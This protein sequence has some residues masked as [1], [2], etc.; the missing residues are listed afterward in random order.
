MARD[1]P[2][3]K[4]DRTIRNIVMAAIG[5][6]VFVAG[7]LIWQAYEYIGVFR[8]LAEWQFATFDRMYPLV[9]IAAIVLILSIPFLIA[10]AVLQMRRRKVHGRF[11][12]GELLVRERVGSRIL[13]FAA[14]GFG[15][16]AGL[17]GL[18][19]LTIGGIGDKAVT[20]FK[21]RGEAPASGMLVRGQAWALA[22]SKGYYR[23]RAIFSTR[24]LFVMP[25]ARSGGGTDIRYFVETDGPQV[26]E[27]RLQAISG[28]MRQNAMPGGLTQLYRNA[29]YRVSNPAHVVFASRQSAR[30]PYTSAAFDSAIIAVLLLI[31]FSMLR[32]HINRALKKEADD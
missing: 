29:G 9:T 27:P 19:A 10:I 21:L 16:V 11:R 31:A 3:R 22:G 25:I 18:F 2:L 5:W 7:I 20:G 30:W 1:T 6:A 8:W 12:R 24:D 17:L 32:L 14:G 13:L 28:V 4:I 23:E 26:S 15:A